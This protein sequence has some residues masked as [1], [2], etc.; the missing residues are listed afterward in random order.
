MSR[1]R[2]VWLG[3]LLAV[4][5]L[6]L[7]WPAL[8]QQT[9]MTV[10]VLIAG[11]GTITSLTSTTATVT[12]M[13]APVT[14]AVPGTPATSGTG[15]LQKLSGTYTA[16]VP[17]GQG[18]SLIELGGHQTQTVSGASQF[19]VLKLN[20]DA[21]AIDTGAGL[22]VENTGR[23]DAIYLRVAGKVGVAANN[24]PTGIG[25]D[26]NRD[27]VSG[28]N[29]T[30][31]AGFG[32]QIWD[33]STDNIATPAQPT[34]LFLRKFSNPNTDH[35]LIVA[36]GNRRLIDL[37][38]PEGVGYVATQ[39][40]LTLL[41]TSGTQK[42]TLQANGDQL[43]TMDRGIFWTMPAG[44]QTYITGTINNHLDVRGGTAGFR[45]LNN[46][47]SA[48][49]LYVR[50]ND[51][52]QI[53]ASLLMLGGFATDPPTYTFSTIGLV[54]NQGTADNE[55]TSWLSDDVAHGMTTQ[56]ATNTFGGVKKAGFTQGGVRLDGY[57][58]DAIGVLI[59][60]SVTNAQTSRTNTALA[61]IMLTGLLKSGTT[62]GPMG[63]DQNLL[64]LR[65]AESGAATKF[66]FTSSGSLYSDLVV[67]SFDDFEDVALLEAIDAGRDLQSALDREFGAYGYTWRDLARLDLAYANPQTGTA[68]VNLSKFTFLLS[69]A[70]RQQAAQMRALEARVQA[71]EARAAA[72]ETER[73]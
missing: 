27:L 10:D 56:T 24:Q 31:F 38:T 42:W 12:S 6:I 65:I 11:T 19:Y 53:P 72:V 67:T 70:I 48:S 13:T 21:D 68:M 1:N 17:T 43:Y 2:F 58:S 44:N 29:S 9:K 47:G 26:L 37:V 69:G 66:I 63:A 41:T 32:I 54:A 18:L 46:T 35:K 57:T 55:I 36:E 30:T 20:T 33:W 15:V 60:G 23:G 34:A 62:V 5:L 49:P 61:P 59:R 25:I 52:V 8:A 16:T 73:R 3:A 7:G 22:M 51:N 50:A 39:P 64:A 14:I 71:A 40:L 28:Q 4:P 45:V